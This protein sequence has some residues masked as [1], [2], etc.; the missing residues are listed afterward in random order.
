MPIGSVFVSPFFLPRRWILGCALCR[1]PGFGF[2][3][4]VREPLVKL[5]RPRYDFERWDWGYFVWPH[6][7]LDGT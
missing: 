3:A 4:A 7:R 6:D 2:A 1:G 5:R